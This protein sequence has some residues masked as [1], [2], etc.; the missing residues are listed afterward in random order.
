VVNGLGAVIGTAPLHGPLEGTMRVLPWAQDPERAVGHQQ[1]SD[2]S[3]DEADLD[4]H[5]AAAEFRLGQHRSD[6][7]AGAP[8]AATVPFGSRI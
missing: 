6:G 7:S 4:G 2:H 3:Q 5:T 1:A 8:M